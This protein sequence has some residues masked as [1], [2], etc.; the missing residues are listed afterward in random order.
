VGKERQRQ[1]R[2]GGEKEGRES[3]RHCPINDEYSRPFYML[4]DKDQNVNKNSTIIE[5]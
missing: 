5:I 4:R 2:G 1:R 3:R